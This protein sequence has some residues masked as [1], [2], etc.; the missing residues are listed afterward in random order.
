MTSHTL[1]H[2]KNN[3]EQS[4]RLKIFNCSQLQNAFCHVREYT[5]VGQRMCVCQGGCLRGTQVR[6]HDTEEIRGS[7]A[8]GTNGIMKGHC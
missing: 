3:P 5:H 6:R 4:F 8:A 1:V 2:H 7:C